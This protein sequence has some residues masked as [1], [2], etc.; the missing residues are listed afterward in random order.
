LSR[1]LVS[2]GGGHS[3]LERLERFD[4]QNAKFCLEPGSSGQRTREVLERIVPSFSSCHPSMLRTRASSKPDLGK[5]EVAIADGHKSCSRRPKAARTDQHRD[6]LDL[7]LWLVR[8]GVGVQLKATTASTLHSF[9]AIKLPDVEPRSGAS[10][11]AFAPTS[12]Q[13]VGSSGHQRHFSSACPWTEKLALD[14]SPDFAL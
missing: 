8:Q 12:R 2:A 6:Q 7:R 10:A 13:T 3:R 14:F 11:F 4:L 9:V 1:E 5:P